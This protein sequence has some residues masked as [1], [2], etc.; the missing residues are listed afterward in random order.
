MHELVYFYHNML[1]VLQREER[2]VLGLVLLRG[3]EVISLTI[4]G[5]PPAD[6]SRAGKGQVAPVSIAFLISLECT[7]FTVP[8]CKP[9]YQL[10]QCLGKPAKLQSTIIDTHSC[11]QSYMQ[12]N[13]QT[14]GPSSMYIVWYTSIT[15]QRA[16]SSC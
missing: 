11:A 3:D 4:E 12:L 6:E 9:L 16:C 8:T 7:A 2:R 1:A 13:S 14:A 5:P 10:L 15:L